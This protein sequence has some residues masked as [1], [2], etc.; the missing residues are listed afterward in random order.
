MAS[1]DTIGDA[2]DLVYPDTAERLPFL[3]RLLSDRG[4]SDVL[5]LGSGSGLFLIPLA[6]RGFAME[7]VE[8]SQEMIRA[9]NMKAPGLVVHHGDVRDF[10]LDH[11]FDA[12]LALSSLPTILGDQAGA[13]ACIARGAAHLRPGGVMV[14]ELP[15]HLVEIA[16]SNHSQE[17]HLSPDESIIV[18]MQ[19]RVEEG[20][21]RERW[22]IFR[23]EGETQIHETAVCEEFLYDPAEMERA[24]VDAGLTIVETYGDLAGGP[25]VAD[26]SWR[27]VWICEKTS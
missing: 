27:R 11:S 23:N 6:E 5:E 7:G 4:A 1:Y 8:L 19:N 16:N 26:A 20:F 18:V 24:V 14:L 10:E 2:Y 25:F 15:N 17:V 3:Q 21:W 22:H 13:S 9:C 12:V